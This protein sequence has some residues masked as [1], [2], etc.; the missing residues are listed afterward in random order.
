ML[1]HVQIGDLEVC[2]CFDVVFYLAVDILFGTFFMNHY[3]HGIF[4]FLRRIALRNL[5]PLY[6][7]ALGR[8]DE[9]STNP[10]ITTDVCTVTGN[11]SD[12]KINAALQMVIPPRSKSSVLYMSTIACIRLWS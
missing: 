8:K 3:V 1:P 12:N 9:T 5:R 11:L 7:S 2:K 4:P 10:I 6:I